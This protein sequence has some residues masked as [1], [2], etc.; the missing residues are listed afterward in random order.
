M[1]A[2]CLA[3]AGDLAQA[4]AV[5]EKPV[6]LGPV[7]IKDRL[8]GNSYFRREADHNRY[9]GALRKAAGDLRL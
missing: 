2:A 5:I 7:Y 8:R 3:E 6:R 1:L 9:V 4:R